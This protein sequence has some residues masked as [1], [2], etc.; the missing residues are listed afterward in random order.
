MFPEKHIPAGSVAT[1]AAAAL[2]RAGKPMKVR[3]IVTALQEAGKFS[4]TDSRT[5]YA[6]VFGILRRDKRFVKLDEGLFGLTERDAPSGIVLR[7]EQSPVAV[8]E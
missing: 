6:T 8:P 3:E 2:R 1:M 7:D 5:H 4:Q